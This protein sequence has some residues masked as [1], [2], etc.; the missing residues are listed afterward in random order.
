M[1]AGIHHPQVARVQKALQAAQ[2][3]SAV[4]PFLPLAITL[5]G[6]EAQPREGLLAA[7]PVTYLHLMLSIRQ[8]AQAP[9]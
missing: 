7:M 9:L 8:T 1:A 6:R 2:A 4:V 3:L 5:E